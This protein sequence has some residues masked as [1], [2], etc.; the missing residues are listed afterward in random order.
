MAEAF[1]TRCHFTLPP[2][3]GWTPETFIGRPRAAIDEILTC[4]LGWDVTDF[5]HGDFAR[6]G[7]LLVTLRNGIPE[8]MRYRKPYAE[9][10]M[11]SREGQ[12]TLTHCHVR[13]TEDIINRAGG[14]LEFRLY[15][16]VGECSLA[17]TPVAFRRDGELCRCAPGEPVRLSPGESITLEPDVFHS[18]VAMPGAGDVLIGEVSSVNDDHTDNV[19]YGVQLRFPTI[20]ED[21]A[22]YRLLVKDYETM[23]P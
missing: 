21:E 13:K 7:L 20:E 18:F 1:F 4:N 3:A 10:I 19:F 6:E 22:P 9:K 12:R 2:F 11:I 8:H 5:G 14:V 23:I 15:N 16:R 17:D